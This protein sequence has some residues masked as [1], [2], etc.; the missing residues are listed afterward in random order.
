MGGMFVTGGPSFAVAVRNKPLSLS[1]GSYREKIQWISKKFFIFW[2]ESDKRGWLVKGTAALLHLTRASLHNDKSAEILGPLLIFNEDT[3]KETPEM[4]TT[5]AGTVLM[6]T[7]NRRLQLFE[8]DDAQED[9]AQPREDFLQHRI[10]ALW[11]TMEKMIDFEAQLNGK[12]GINV[13]KR[14]RRHLEGWDVRD[15]ASRDFPFYHRVATLNR[16]GKGWVDWVRKINAVALFGRGFGELIEPAPSARGKHCSYW[17][18]LPKNRYY[19]AVA[20]QDMSIIVDRDGDPYLCPV[21]LCDGLFLHPPASSQYRECRCRATGARNLLSRSGI[22]DRHSQLVH[23]ILPR[24]KTGRIESYP[25]GV[26][27]GNGAVVLGHNE[28][29]P[30]HWGDHGDPVQNP[31]ELEPA[32]MEVPAEIPENPNLLSDLPSSDAGSSSQDAGSPSQGLTT[33]GPSETSTPIT[34]AMASLSTSYTGGSASPGAQDSASRSQHGSRTAMP[35]G[36]KADKEAGS[37]ENTQ[38]ALHALKHAKRRK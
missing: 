36:A 9:A 2:D 37:E 5:S 1:F 21:Q 7:K 27:L 38:R 32:E 15:V 3:L 29:L 13:P 16:V 35:R 10:E 8:R 30:W 11:E 19:L 24:N 14:I 6:D 28:D 31:S 18:R 25:D 34:S 17:D 23:Y 26:C 33:S 12:D 4:T 20:A 22:A